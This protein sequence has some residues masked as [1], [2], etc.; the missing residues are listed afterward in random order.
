MLPP[1]LEIFV[2]WHPDDAGGRHAAEQ[3]IQ[4]FHGTTFSGLLGGAI[5]IYARSDGWT[6]SADAPR[7]VPLPGEPPPN[8]VAQ[9]QLTVVVPVLGHG[10]AAAVEQGGA[11]RDYLSHIAD[12]Q[13]AAPD[14]VGIFPLQLHPQATDGTQLARI[15]GRFQRIAAPAAGTPTEDEAGLRCRDLTQGI[16]Q[17]GS[18]N[19][20]RLTVF[21]SHTKRSAPDAE[22]DVLG[23]V[24]QVRAII[25]DTRL[26]DYFDARDLQPGQ[27]WDAALRAH[28]ATGALL[29]LRTDLYASREWCQREMSIAKQ[30]GLPV[31]IMDS[32]G[33]G[34]ERGSYLLDHVARIPVQ[35]LN[36]EWSRAGILRCLNLLVDESL[37]RVLWRRQQALAEGVT[38]L[39]V[40][41]WAPHAPELMTLTA[42]IE[43]NRNGD[44]MPSTG[45]PLRI[46]HPD[47]PLGPEELRILKQLAAVAGILNELDIVTPRLLALRGF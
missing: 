2:V 29:A 15:F 46:L 12:A 26:A 41:W 14:R 28:A 21:I 24:N 6:S 9:A 32:L 47:P 27:D 10:L 5:E 43:E 17:L 20:E 23:L 25:A 35:R 44:R 11:W 4:H 36:H 8:G 30:H 31:V 13:A 45:D 16:A 7:P 18:P 39:D 42:W 3:L 38:D 19:P 37:K 33:R 22:E 34:E 40:A 1:L